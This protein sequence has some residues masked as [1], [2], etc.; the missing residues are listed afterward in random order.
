MLGWIERVLP[1]PPGTS[2]Q[3]PLVEKGDRKADPRVTTVAPRPGEAEQLPKGNSTCPGKSSSCG[4]T[5]GAGKKVT[6]I[7]TR[8][9]GPSSVS[10][11]ESAGRG[12]LSWLSQELGKVVPQPAQNPG[13][14]QAI[15]KS[16]ENSLDFPDQTEVQS[17]KEDDDLL[18]ITTLAPD[19][20]ELQDHSELHCS[21]DNNASEKE[22][23]SRVISWLM[24]GFGKMIPQ[25]EN[26]NKLEDVAEGKAEEA[27]VREAESKVSKTRTA[28]KGSSQA[29]HSVSGTSQQ[30]ST[31]GLS[32]LGASLSPQMLRGDGS[33]VVKWFVQGM[34]KVIP[35]PVA[36]VKQDAQAAEVATLCPVEER[37]EGA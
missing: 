10:S 34:E 35:K 27:A 6:F 24:Q 9:P 12:V 17:I 29:S 32:G 1:H 20:D 11:T 21:S 19:E 3:P 15:R 14:R 26:L 23:G 5:E 33:R 8:E 37:G 30:A 25:P 22:T 36:R 4:Q 13:M 2:H 28:P 18:E 7:T 16:F 31:D